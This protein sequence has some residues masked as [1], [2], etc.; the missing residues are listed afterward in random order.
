MKKSL[1]FLAALATLF[2]ACNNSDSEPEAVENKLDYSSYLGKSNAQIVEAFGEG[3]AMNSI[4]MY[5][6]IGE[7]VTMLSFLFNADDQVYMISQMID[8]GK[9]AQTEFVSY[10]AEKYK[11][12]T[13]E[14][15]VTY[16]NNSDLSAATIVI[17]ISE[18]E[19]GT[20]TVMYIDPSLNVTSQ[21]EPLEMGVYE[22]VDTFLGADLATVLDDY[23]DS[24]YE[25]M[26]MTMAE[27]DDEYATV[28]MLVADEEGN[29][30]SVS[31]LAEDADDQDLVAMFT[32]NGY[33]LVDV[34]DQE[35]DGYEY[36][37]YCLTKDDIALT[38]S[39]GLVMA[40]LGS[41]GED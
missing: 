35:D 5:M 40:I 18:V 1:L 26:G 15:E 37:E 38:V 8:D 27:V 3:I 31:V 34:I 33:T 17:T 21:N 13:E 22:L 16:A 39:D 4:V 28:I 24:F 29:I 23:S 10:L 7:E 19:E 2:V 20:Y 11:T 32:D 30:V 36:K 14:G 6:P 9:Y 12:V 41:L 25:T